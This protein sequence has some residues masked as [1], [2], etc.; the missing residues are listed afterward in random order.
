MAGSNT[1]ITHKKGMF[2]MGEPVR[3]ESLSVD[4]SEAYSTQKSF[5]QEIELTGPT[6]VREL[7]RTISSKSNYRGLLTLTIRLGHQQVWRLKNSKVSAANDSIQRPLRTKEEC[8]ARH[9][10]LG[11]HV[12]SFHSAH[13]RALE[14]APPDTSDVHG[15]TDHHD[16]HVQMHQY[17]M[18]GNAGQARSAAAAAR[19]AYDKSGTNNVERFKR[20]QELEHESVLADNYEARLDAVASANSVNYLD[21][22]STHVRGHM[23]DIAA[24]EDPKRSVNVDDEKVQKLFY[25]VVESCTKIVHGAKYLHNV[26]QDE[27]TFIIEGG[28]KSLMISNSEHL[29][30]MLAALLRMMVL[31]KCIEAIFMIAPWLWS[32]Q[33]AHA[34]TEAAAFNN[35]IHNASGSLARFVNDVATRNAIREATRRDEVEDFQRKY[36]NVMTAIGAFTG[37]LSAVASIIK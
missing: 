9:A 32:S 27:A 18:A 30:R 3:Q 12:N 35:E 2:G 20:M 17:P 26:A 36:A 25:G 8:R 11:N 28:S 33:V 22:I 16:T 23:A 1:S 10:Y 37:T 6:K 29:S 34:Y 13:L 14:H 19:R 15:M 24:P 7:I 31:A 4:I 21:A 5:E